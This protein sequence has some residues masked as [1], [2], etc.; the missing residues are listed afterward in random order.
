MDTNKEWSKAHPVGSKVQLCSGKAEY[1][2]VSEAFFAPGQ[3]CVLLENEG[4]QL[5]VPLDAIKGFME[6]FLPN[7]ERTHADD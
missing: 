4:H 1:S 5:A 6:M 2:V 3:H 7:V